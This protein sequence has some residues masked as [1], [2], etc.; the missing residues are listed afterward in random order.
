MHVKELPP[1]APVVATVP[2]RTTSR[3]LMTATA[4]LLALGTLTALPSP[5]HAASPPPAP[6]EVTAVRTSATAVTVGWTDPSRQ[7]RR[8]SIRV[9]DKL[10]GPWTQLRS[11]NDKRKNPPARHAA[12]FP[13]LPQAKV[14]CY[15]VTASQ[16]LQHTTSAPACAAPTLPNTPTNLNVSWGPPRRITVNALNGPEWE[17]G[18]RSYTKRQGTA[19]WVLTSETVPEERHGSLLTFALVDVLRP[20]THYCLRLTAFNPLGETPPTNERCGMTG[21]APPVAPRDL[22]SYG[23]TSTKVSLEWTFLPPRP[24][25][26][27]TFLLRRDTDSIDREITVKH[28]EHASGSQTYTDSGLTPGKRCTYRVEVQSPGG[29]SHTKPLSVQTL[30][31][32]PPRPV[33]AELGFNGS[34]WHSPTHPRPGEPFTLHWTTCN[35]GGTT[36]PGFTSVAQLDGNVN[37]PVTVPSL[38][39]GRCHDST[40]TRAGL[41]S[42]EHY[43]YV[44]LDTA[45]Q[46]PEQNENNNRLGF[47]FRI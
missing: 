14:Y 31:K 45:G 4:A 27:H 15:Q 36:A 8:W 38:A 26:T 20:D 21:E 11:I 39:P 10:N 6:T 17:W 22:R 2:H 43:W 28:F 12:T 33:K 34:L 30:K 44:Y 46:V 47:I 23:V 32:G 1:R 19:S 9:Q 35:F 40:V 3:A 7:V 41:S 13:N 25:T 18:Y 24:S 29:T 37:H 42:G 5:A 16:D